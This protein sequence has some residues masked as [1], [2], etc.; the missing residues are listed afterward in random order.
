MEIFYLLFR[1]QNPKLVSNAV[2]KQQH[3][4]AGLS[5]AIIGNNKVTPTKAAYNSINH[6]SK[7]KSAAQQGDPLAMAMVNEGKN[8][9]IYLFI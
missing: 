8:K 5:T 1:N 6:L 9:V 3:V 4:Q 7:M 2:L